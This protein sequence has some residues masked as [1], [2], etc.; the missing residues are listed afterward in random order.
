[1]APCTGGLVVR[2][3]VWPPSSDVAVSALSFDAKSPPPTMPCDGSRNATEIAP[4]LGEL[5]SGVSDAIQVSPP[6]LVARILAIVEPP[7]AIHALLFPCAAMQVP[8]AANDA[9]PDN[10]GGIL[11]AMDCQ[12]V[13]SVVRMSGNTPFTESLCVTPRFGVQNAKQS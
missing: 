2:I 4:A 11:A 9:S 7:V 8:L 10:A 12:V 5:T 6:S 1:M 3:H 13:P